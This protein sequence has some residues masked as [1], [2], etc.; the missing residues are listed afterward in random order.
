MPS[1]DTNPERTVGARL[2]SRAQKLTPEQRK[3]AERTAAAIDR[4]VEKHLA[5]VQGIPNLAQRAASADYLMQLANRLAD[6]AQDERNDA[7]KKMVQ[8]TGSTRERAEVIKEIAQSLLMTEGRVR[9][10][11]AGEYGHEVRATQVDAVLS[12]EFLQREYVERERTTTD[13]AEEVG[14]DPQTVSNYLR[15]HGIPVR[16]RGSRRKAS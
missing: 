4:D 15:R 10:I 9:Q 7:I 14:C 1:A 2:G 12:K 16:S 11:A 6:G 8:Q 3:Q 5:R 13:I